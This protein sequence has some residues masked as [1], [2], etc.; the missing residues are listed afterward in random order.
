MI[1]WDELFQFLMLITAIATLFFYNWQR[2]MTAPVLRK[3]S[4]H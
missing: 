4:G 2:K 1:T 3:L